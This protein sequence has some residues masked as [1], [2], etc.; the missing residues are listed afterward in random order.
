[1]LIILALIAVAVV[2]GI[3]SY[4]GLVGLK[5]RTENSWSDI[6]VQ[7]KRRYDLIPNLV[8]TV[9][10]YAAHEKQLF[11]QVTEAR[12]K[13]MQAQG[14]QE[15]GSAESALTNTVKSLF[16]IAENYPQL[17]A[18]ENFLSLQQSLS[19]TEEAIQSSRRYYNAVVR[20]YNTKQSVIPDTF[21][22]KIGGFTPKEFF[23]LES[24][25]EAKTPKVSF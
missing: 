21:I 10:G 13:A 25:E 1:M 22:A 14:P 23:Q 4:N 2:W 15:K 7:L 9:Q 5:V 8:S 20:D 3:A 18:N 16:A 24:Q 11:A 6:N 17:K 12:S 19:Q